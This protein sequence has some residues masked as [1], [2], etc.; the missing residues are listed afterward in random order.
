MSNTFGGLYGS[1]QQQTKLA[2][3]RA[4]NSLKK[5]HGNLKDTEL[6]ETKIITHNGQ[7]VY[8]IELWQKVDAEHFTV[9]AVVETQPLKVADIKKMNQKPAEPTRPL[10]PEPS[11]NEKAKDLLS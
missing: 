4:R 9:S 2:L 7:A 10:D 6:R 3:E 5:K 11:T 8:S 1:F